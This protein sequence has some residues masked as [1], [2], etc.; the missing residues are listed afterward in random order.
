MSGE[1]KMDTMSVA[2][3]MLERSDVAV[4]EDHYTAH[5]GE[6]EFTDFRI[7]FRCLERSGFERPQ[8]GVEISSDGLRW[9]VL[10]RKCR[11]IGRVRWLSFRLW[12]PSC[13][14]ATW[15]CEDGLCIRFVHEYECISDRQWHIPSREF[16][17]VL[18]PGA[19]RWKI[20]TP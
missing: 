14:H 11:A 13:I 4:F 19:A 12:P 18:Q 5:L 2:G 20:S 10:T 16:V 15:L 7:R 9:L 8:Y 17:A 3:F 1:V 6:R